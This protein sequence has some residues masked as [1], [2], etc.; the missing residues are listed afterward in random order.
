MPIGSWREY[1]I[2]LEEELRRGVDSESFRH[3]QIQ[4]LDGTSVTFR[5]AAD[6]RAELNMARAEEYKEGL[7]SASG[8]SPFLA[9]VG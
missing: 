5:S 6:L 2:R 3:S 9:E 7:S 8:S 1:R 4:R